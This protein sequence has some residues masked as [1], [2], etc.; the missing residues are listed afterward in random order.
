MKK[1]KGEEKWKM[2][3]KLKRKK[4]EEGVRKEMKR[5]A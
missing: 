5:R 2:Q 4:R 1:P 3:I